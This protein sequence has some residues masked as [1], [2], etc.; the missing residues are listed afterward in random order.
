MAY[1]NLFH[2]LFF[3]SEICCKKMFWP[4]FS[5]ASQ[6]YFHG[7]ST[8]WWW[9]LA[10]PPWRLVSKGTSA[11][12]DAGSSPDGGTCGCPE[13]GSGDPGGR[14]LSRPLWRLV[15]RQRY[16]SPPRKKAADAAP[17]QRWML[18]AP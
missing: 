7:L 2:F 9:M 4:K 5:I 18:G 3:P 16:L 13:G 17:E 15:R 10:C 1:V 12:V 14:A 8:V 6:L 11:T